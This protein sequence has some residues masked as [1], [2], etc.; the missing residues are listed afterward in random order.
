MILKGEIQ[1]SVEQNKAAQL[2]VWEEVFNSGNLDVIPE[3]FAPAYSFRSPLGIEAKG[4]EGFK[5]MIAMMRSALPD[6]HV[7]VDD[8]FGE[9]D[10]VATRATIIGTFKNE[11]MGIPPTGKRLSIPVTLISRWEGGKEV[12]AWESLDTLSFYQQLGIRPPQVM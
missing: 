1:M 5:Q 8:M 11:M 12:E 10:R 4:P 7:T 9:G 2:R 6:L 3:F